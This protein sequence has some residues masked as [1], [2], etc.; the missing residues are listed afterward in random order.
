MGVAKAIGAREVPG[1]AKTLH[2]QALLAKFLHYTFT[3]NIGIKFA[4]FCKFNNSLGDH[5]IGKIA[6]VCNVQGDASHFECHAHDTPG[7][8]IKFGIA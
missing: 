1:A 7:L 8:G 4:G 2:L 3:Q 6:A 5:L